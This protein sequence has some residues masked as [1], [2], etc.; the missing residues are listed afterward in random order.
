MDRAVNA[1]GHYNS[2]HEGYAVI[3][4]EVDELWDEVKRQAH[5]RSDQQIYNESYDIAIAALKMA[6][7]AKQRLDDNTAPE[8]AYPS[9]ADIIYDGREDQ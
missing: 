3:L 5:V 1:H 9:K 8:E 4:E 7:L 2:Y 6:F